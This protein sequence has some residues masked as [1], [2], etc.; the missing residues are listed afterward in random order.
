[1]LWNKY[2]YHKIQQQLIACLARFI[3]VAAGRRSGKTDIAKKLLIQRA[4]N[5]PILDANYV[6]S[7]P[8]YSQSKRIF[9]RD[10]KRLLPHSLVRKIAEA[11]LT[12]HT[13]VSSAI[14]VT[15]MD[16]P[17]RIEGTP[18]D[19]IILDEY[20]NMK[21]SVWPEHVRP[22]LFTEGRPPGWAIIIGVPEGRNHFYDLYQEAQE[23]Q[24][25]GASAALSGG[26]S[27]QR[28]GAS[29][30]AAFTW[31]SEDIL[32]PEEILSAKSSLDA[33]TYAQ[34]YEASFIS[35]QGR[36]YPPFSRELHAS[37]RLYYTP[38]QDLIFCFD[39][40][41]DPGVAVVIQEMGD[42]GVLSGVS[43]ALSGGDSS[44]LRGD[45]TQSSGV[46]RSHAI[47]EVYIP[48]ISNTLRV[49]EKLRSLTYTTPHIDRGGHIYFYGDS[50]G[51]ASGSAKIAGSDWDIIRRYFAEHYREAYNQG[52]FHFSYPRQNPNQ[53]PRINAMNSRLLSMDNTVRFLVDPVGCPRLIKDFEG[54]TVIEGTSGEIDKNADKKL[55]HLSDA[56][57][58]YI[59][60][61]YPIVLRSITSQAYA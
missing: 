17:E 60:E 51:G 56:V 25:E 27:A 50:T 43:A 45:S 13:I 47:Q 42:S 38:E 5:P 33:L 46:S 21:P 1:M 7:A 32:P 9:W 24:A 28:G 41:R 4:L 54:V 20:A 40:N 52:Q 12:V 35:F 31:K 14:T 16:M 57:G 23:R 22:A 18:L 8:T 53:R 44:T 61:K 34:E 36:A 39:F 48:K 30:W 55:T 37:T 29:D 26:S 59:A 3:V 11:D 15:G 2:R 10:M 58:Y 49:C 6:C 19:G